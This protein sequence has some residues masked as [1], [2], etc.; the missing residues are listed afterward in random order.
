MAAPANVKVPQGW[1]VEPDGKR[2]SV[3][4]KTKDFLSAL[5]L[6]E[7]IGDAAEELEHHPDL[8]LE[9]WNHVRIVT[10]SHDVGRLTERDEAL[11]ERITE[12]LKDRKL[13]W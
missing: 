3:E 9:Q 13:V 1:R 6:F 5:D 10:Y 8:H 4:V 2:M 12:I 11:A 7:E